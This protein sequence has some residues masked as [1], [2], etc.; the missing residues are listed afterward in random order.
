MT[1][2]NTKTLADWT[3]AEYK[4][5]CIAF[6]AQVPDDGICEKTDGCILREA[7]ICKA[8][9]MWPHLW[10][11]SGL[12]GKEI[13][14]AKLVDGAKYITRVNGFVKFWTEKPQKFVGGVHDA[15]DEKCAGMM[16]GNLFPSVQ[17]GQIIFLGDAYPPIIQLESDGE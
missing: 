2:S 7:G 3:G 11:L 14:L 15:P 6:R 16:S 17:P 5:Y 10:N 9:N 12:S 4:Q 8:S 13:E 1:W